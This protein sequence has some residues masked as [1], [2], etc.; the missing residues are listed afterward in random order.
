MTLQLSF[1][2]RRI[3]IDSPIDSGF[4]FIL[5]NV[6]NPPSMAPSSA[7]S[8]FIT[9]TDGFNVSTITSG[10]TV[11]NTK[12]SNMTQISIK[13][14]VYADGKWTNLT[15]SVVPKNYMQF[16]TMTI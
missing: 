10:P 9:S 12:P 14:S 1:S 15:F 8:V 5:T 6:Q 4:D 11:A 2:W 7:F 3:L 16:M 13:P